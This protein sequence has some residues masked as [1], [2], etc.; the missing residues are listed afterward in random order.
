[1]TPPYQPVLIY[2]G[3]CGFC[4][5]CVDI[6]FAITGDKVKYRPYQEAASDFPAIKEDAFK[7]SVQLIEQ[8]G[9]VSQKAEAVFKTLA[10]GS[11]FFKAVLF[12][13]NKLPGFSLITTYSYDLV[14]R[15]RAF[16]FK[17]FKYICWEIY[18]K[19]DYILIYASLISKGY[20]LSIFIR[21][22]S[23]NPTNNGIMG[24]YR[25]IAY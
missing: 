24:K 3:D 15:N 22:C 19:K 9:R 21:I 4:K 17:E 10:I 1:M 7:H 11:F 13:Y 2:D 25:R 23:A 12:L 16:F 8:G 20:G 5:R 14:A 18:S 6:A